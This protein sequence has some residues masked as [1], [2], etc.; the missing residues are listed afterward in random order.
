MRRISAAF[1]IMAA[2]CC[3]TP[4]AFAGSTVDDVTAS[5]VADT[6]IPAIV[7]QRMETTVTAIGA[8]LLSGRKISEVEAERQ[9]QEAIIHEVFDKVL[10]GYTVESVTLTP[11]EKARVE[12]RLLPWADVVRA[13]HVD[14]LVEGMP[15]FV[16]ELARR[17]LADVGSVFDEGLQGLPVAASDWTNGVLKRSLQDY[18]DAHLPEFRADFDVLPGPETKVSLTVYPRL[19]VVRTIDLSMRSDSIPNFTLLNHRKLMQDTVNMMIGVPV[20]FVERHEQEFSDRFAATLDTLGDFRALD[21]HTVVTMK[22]GS[23]MSVMSRSDTKAYLIRLEGWADIG[24]RDDDDISRAVFRLHLGKRFS[25]RDEFFLQT[26]IAP[27][28][29]RWTWEL[30]YTRHLAEATRLTLRYD[31][32]EKDFILGGEQELGRK[33]MLRYEYRWTDQLGEGA[34]RYRLHDFL[35]LEYVISTDDKWV[36]LIGNF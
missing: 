31:M 24:R 13:V 10:V 35:S 3:C 19:P 29:V 11:G 27:Q 16:E 8:Q 28:D 15:P 23:D 22:P 9:K 25:P 36:R 2:S 6:P 30:G 20:A 34:L 21:L 26:D 14:V 12:I 4:T 33:W 32:R 17:D 1:C 5:V 7:R 18:M